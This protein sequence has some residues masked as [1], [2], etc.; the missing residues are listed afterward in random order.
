MPRHTSPNPLLVTE[1]S[2]QSQV[3]AIAKL[4]GWKVQHTRT[5][6]IRPGKWATPLQGHAGFPDLVLCHP[7]RGLIFAELKTNTG[8]VA[9]HQKAWLDELEQTGA[10]VYVWRPRDL[11]Y[12]EARLTKGRRP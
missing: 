5:V 2:F 8:R 7:D 11:R 4:A 12:I 3:L 1:A 6:Q 10:E 9:P